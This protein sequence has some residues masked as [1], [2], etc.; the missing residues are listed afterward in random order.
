MAT[1]RPYN[2]AKIFQ[3]FDALPGFREKLQAKEKEHERDTAP[4]VDAERAQE[5]DAITRHLRPGQ[6]VLV[7]YFAHEKR[8]AQRTTFRALDKES[9]QILFADLALSPRDIYSIAPL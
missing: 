3:P 6:P 1:A 2:R 8:R 7:R 9:C 5:L 4:S